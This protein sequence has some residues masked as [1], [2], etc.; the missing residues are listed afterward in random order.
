MRMGSRGT[1][2]GPGADGALPSQKFVDDCDVLL[3]GVL[4][5]AGINS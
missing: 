3:L 2:L 5:W 1:P 4:D